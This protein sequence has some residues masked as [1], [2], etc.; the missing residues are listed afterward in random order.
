MTSLSPVHHPVTSGKPAGARPLRVLYA[1]DMEELR[2]PM[3][4]VMAREGHQLET[5][6][7]G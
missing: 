1:D 2:V 4:F 5:C 3:G 7:N 6:K